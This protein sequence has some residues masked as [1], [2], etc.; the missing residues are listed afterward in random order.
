MNPQSFRHARRDLFRFLM[1]RTQ[2]D[3]MKRARIF[4]ALILL[5]SFS[6]A[7]HADQA[8]SAFKK[9]VQA[10]SKNDY[11]EAF[12]DYSQ[13]HSLK[14][15]DAKYFTAFT[16]MRF[17]AAVQH[18]SKAQALR[19]GGKLQEAVAEFQR[20]AEI[21]PTNF[22][23]KT[24]AHRTEEIIKKQARASEET[25]KKEL[26]LDKMA[27]EAAGPVELQQLSNTLISLRLTENA[28]MVYKTIAHLAGI[29]VLFD[30]DYKPPKITVELND[31]TLREALNTVALQTKTFWTPV[32]SNTILIAADT[33]AKRKDMENSVM[34]TFYLKNVS[35][36]GELQEAAA[37]LKS[38]LDLNRIQLVPN[39]NALILR[40]TTDQ[41]VLAQKLLT[42]LDKPK[43]E[44]V[45]EIAVLQVSRSRIRNLGVNPPTSANIVMVPGTTGASSGGSG[46]SFTLNSL[47]ALNATNFQVNI[48]GA[49]VTY[50][51]SDSDTKLIQNPQIRAL[52]NEKATLKI[53][54][55]VPV[56]TGS[57]GSAA[58][59]GGVSALVNTQFQYL[60]VGVNID[61][62]PHIHSEHEVTLKM[63]LEV[64]SVSGTQN[65][66]GISQPIIGQRRIEHETRLRDGEV[67]LVGGILEDT[68]TTSLSGYPWLTKIP[69]LKYLFGQEDKQRQENEIVFAI[70]PHIVRA[71][72]VTDDNLRLVDLG[73][74]TSVT[75]GHTDPRRNAPARTPNTMEQTASPN[76]PNRNAP[77][78]AVT[79]PPAA[80][81]KPEPSR[82][83][84]P[85]QIPSAVTTTTLVR[86]VKATPDEQKL[87]L[88][89]PERAKPRSTEAT[90]DPCP[91][92]MHSIGTQYGVLNCAF[93]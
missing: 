9:G 18:V 1:G 93:D 66:G 20:A 92:G 58:G 80:P 85:A 79:P 40:G 53:G 35:T 76:S 84:A 29:N 64:S 6:V 86:P 5:V 30:Q 81:P 57:F 3:T 51:M 21:D 75:V 52:D 44:V 54:D 12:Q 32:S 63:S 25:A 28:T 82:T 15:K 60:D 43:P 36:P 48:P 67:N 7:A 10:E 89:P 26:P 83:P 17:Y 47:G 33:T 71:Q 45:I 4:A 2:T 50:L 37:T 46:G 49:S 56:A 65:I 77:Q 42:D 73:R 38:I 62:T 69:I 55:R 41:M 19:D 91:Y 68:E 31:V 16:R 24:E 87:S 39:Q 88:Q 11:D 23:A 8:S 61:I 34:K 70:T 13:A 22:A 72:E 78:K 59:G 27:Q 74:G 14:P 90:A